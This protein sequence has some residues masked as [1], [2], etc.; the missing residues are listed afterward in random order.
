MSDRVDNNVEDLRLQIRLE[1]TEGKCG[2]RRAT[3]IVST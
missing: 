1:P 2:M 3:A